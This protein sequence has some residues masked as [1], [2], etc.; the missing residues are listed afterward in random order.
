[1][2]LKPQALL[3]MN[4]GTFADQFDTT[5]MERLARLVDLGDLPWTDSLDAP[6]LA[7][8]LAKVEILLTSWGVPRLNG[9]R[10]GRM[11]NLRAVFHC[12]G[13]VRSFVSQ[14][15]W[16][17]GIL[18][19]NG[20]D[21]NAI[22]VAEF[23]FA[24]I[25]LA[26]KKAHVLANDSRIFREDWSYATGRG[27]L[28]NIGRVIG[29]IGFSRIGR[30]VVQLVQQLQDV[31]C[32]VSDPHADPAA[33]S[34]AGGKLVSLPELLAA[35]DI[36][37]VHAPALPETRHM[38]GAAE[39]QA[40]KDH[41]TLINTARGSLV[42]TGALE[43]ECAT[44]RIHA[45]L[46]VTEPEPLPAE[47]V[48]YDLPNVIMTPHIAGSLGT[49]TRRMSDAALDDLERYLTGQQLLA[50]VVSDDLGLSA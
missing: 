27:E 34:A 36:V 37:S 2:S 46:D 30:R 31:T 7:G 22:P 3:V 6:E 16:E 1:M 35:S 14:E 18:V 8:R 45:I 20:A 23:T 10:L 4:S 13:T 25:V 24:S 26:G 49:E 50:Q 12:A 33:V 19:T 15:L 21:A 43:K 28:G 5:R 40:M 42:D 38:I 44:G 48:L 41:A 32:L 11:P 39:L 29:V 17:R 47:S 9:D